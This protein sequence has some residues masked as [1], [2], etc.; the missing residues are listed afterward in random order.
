M[1][2]K[3]EFFFAAVFFFSLGF[4]SFPQG[5]ENAEAKVKPFS[6]SVTPFFS[7]DFAGQGEYVHHK[8]SDMVWS[9]LNWESYPLFNA[10]IGLDFSIFGVG[11]SASVK[12]AFPGAC[13]KMEDSDW[14]NV[15]DSLDPGKYGGIKSRY[16][17]SDNYLESSLDVR[18]RI[19]YDFHI[20]K[21]FTLSP[22]IGFDFNHTAFV[23]RGLD[24]SYSQKI[25]GYYRQWDDPAYSSAQ[26]KDSSVDVITLVRNRFMTWFGFRWSVRMG[27]CFYT[28]VEWSLSPFCWIESL[29]S[30]I[31]RSTLFYDLMHGFFQSVSA[32]FEIGWQF[33]SKNRLGFN[34]EYTYLGKI[35]GNTSSGA[36]YSKKVYP[37]SD[38]YA[39][40]DYS[41]LSI[42][43]SYTYIFL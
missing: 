37:S 28:G 3:I 29:D 2:N 6:I 32:A 25:G 33:N 27:K 13:G 1:K 5:T 17:K 15:H 4:Q 26:Y 31:L 7:V 8:D 9:Y 20:N 12:G 34:V 42:T 40:A 22:V 36:M 10:G 43:L 38:S 23:A 24:G 19:F 21:I 11:V 39:A 41:S 16:T 18:T 30:H 35:Y 14:D